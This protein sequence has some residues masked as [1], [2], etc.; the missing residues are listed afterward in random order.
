MHR[1]LATLARLHIALMLVA[2]AL[3]ACTAAP[4]PTL[5]P[6]STLAPTSTPASRPTATPSPAAEALRGVR[7]IV[8]PANL[9]WPRQVEG[10]NGVVSIPAKPQRIITASIGHD[11]M[12]LALVPI[13]RLVGVGAVSK[14]PTYSN[15]ARML[16]SRA[17]VSRE[18]ETII[19]LAP[20]VVVTSPYFPEEGIAA[21]SRVGIPVVQTEL[22]QHPEA[23]INAILLMGYILGEEERAVEFAVEV[24]MRLGSLAEATA[25]AGPRPRVLAA[26]RYADELWVAGAGSTEGGVITAAGGV[27]AAAAIDGNQTTSL[28]G[29]IAMA[30]EVIVIPQPVEFGAEE[31]LQYL[32]GS[33]ALAEVPAIKSGQVHVVESRLY[34]TLSYWNIRGAEDLAQLLW[35]DLFQD[36]ETIPFSLPE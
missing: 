34:T 25:S 33:E 23:R 15:V 30:P 36:T 4:T 2:A 10:L 6:T 22:R 11:E 27:N 8:D 29:V 12:I 32:L 17:E 20:D 19:A 21:L 26:T 14:D 31:F 5:V 7:G 1:K 9:G 18:P 28:E 16:E 3:A 35:P 13:E 24:Q